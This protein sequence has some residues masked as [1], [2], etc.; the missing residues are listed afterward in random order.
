MAGSYYDVDAL[1]GE[2]ERVGCEALFGAVGLGFLDATCE[3]ADL[4]AHSRVELPLWAAR[5]LAERRFVAVDTPKAYAHRFRTYL[6]A[7]PVVMNLRERSPHFYETGLELAHFVRDSQALMETLV[8]ALSE[9][10]SDLLDKSQNSRDEDCSAL[11]SA[12]PELEQLLFRM[13]HQGAYDVYLYKRRSVQSVA[14]S[15]RA[16]LIE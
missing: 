13:G 7:D 4:A 16:R 9:R 2:E 15:K 12:M 8:R 5:K 1:L 10:F 11:T 14:S 3:G 6:L